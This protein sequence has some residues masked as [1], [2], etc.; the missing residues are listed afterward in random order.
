MLHILKQYKH[1]EA[2][3]NCDSVELEFCIQCFI[4]NIYEVIHHLFYCAQL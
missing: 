4:L 2:T 1:T 3:W